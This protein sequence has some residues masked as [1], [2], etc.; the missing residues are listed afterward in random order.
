[1]T[2]TSLFG[3]PYYQLSKKTFFFSWITYLKFIFKKID[4]RLSG[5]YRKNFEGCE[6]FKKEEG[7]TWW[8]RFTF[9]SKRTLE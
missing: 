7:L 3:E 1:L 4:L 9:T 8:N 5:L 2:E 6:W